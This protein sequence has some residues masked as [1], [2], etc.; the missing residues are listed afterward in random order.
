M[1]DTILP[2]ERQPRP[3]RYLFLDLNSYFASVEQ[4]EDPALRGRPVAVC[5]VDA[6]S[7]FVIAA[8]YEAKAFG[9]KTGT[10]IRDAKFMCPGLVMVKARPTVYVAYHKRVQEVAEQVLPIDKVCSIDEMRFRII[11]AEQQPGRAQELALEMKKRLRE[12]IG[13][14]MTASIGIA[15]NAFLAK[16]GTELQ[17]P[18]GL[19]TLTAQDLPERLYSL[20]LTDFTGINRRMQARLNAAGIFSAKD[21]CNTPRRQLRDAFG[22]MTGERW[23]Y[24]LR[25]FDL[26]EEETNRKSLSHSHVLPP[27]LRN[28]KG[29]RDVLM[30][31]LQKASARLRANQLWAEHL[32]VYVRGFDRSWEAQ[33]PLPPTQDTVTMT[34]ALLKL[35]EGHDFV[36]PRGVGVVLTQL[37]ERVGVTPSL[38]EETEDRSDLMAAVDTV[39]Q[40][41][42][43][44]SVFIA[45]MERAKNSADEKIAF[46]KTWLFQEGKG[47]NE[48]IDTFRGLRN[49]EDF[50]E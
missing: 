43:K 45:G 47:D 9:V 32:T 28:E 12:D 2:L 24:L 42:G 50:D 20:K 34:D 4:N 30:R 11:G 14:C 33:A 27:N 13:P 40:K 6:D 5:A 8:S 41:F 10:L 18:D 29:C 48:W 15:P 22:S 35:W 26:P 46:N 7:S 1:V 19:V 31:L 49:S 36:R 37:K 17:K 38:F 23:W 16:I 39:N 25:G 44:N 3:L 21:L